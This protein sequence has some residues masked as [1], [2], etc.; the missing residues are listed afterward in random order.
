MKIAASILF[1]A[2][3]LE[4]ALV[5]ANELIRPPSLFSTLYLVYLTGT[6]EDNLL[7]VG[8][9]SKF[10]AGARGETSVHAIQLENTMAPFTKYHF[11][12]S[13]I[14][15]PLIPSIIAGE[16]FIVNIDAGVLRGREF[17]GFVENFVSDLCHDRSEWVL[18]AICDSA[19]GQI[20]AALV[21][22]PYNKLY[23]AGQFLL[24][25][26][27]MYSWSNWQSRYIHNYSVFYQH[28]LYAE[29]EL[30]CLTALEGELVALPGAES[31]VVAQLNG[32]VLYGK[33]ERLPDT[34]AEKCVSFKFGGSIKPWKYWVLDPNKS[35]YTRRRAL[36]ESWCVLASNPLIEKNRAMTIRQ[37]WPLDFLK[38]FD[39]YLLRN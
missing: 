22:G 17:D 13:I 33:S 27:R 18:S 2:N 7:V 8:L 28:L 25:N 39:F 19:E 6:Q 14:Y 1:D 9:L 26:S 30:M 32:D 15:K 36:L 10:L 35:I 38:A 24:F 11:N 4:P 29:Q 20:P 5:T 23:P 3:Y 16:P 34:Y 12:N 31:V 37:E 21:G